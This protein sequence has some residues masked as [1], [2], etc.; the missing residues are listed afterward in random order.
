[1]FSMKVYGATVFH[2]TINIFKMN[3]MF[4]VFDEKLSN[5]FPDTATFIL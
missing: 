1:M 3:Q 2:S 4:Y 5:E